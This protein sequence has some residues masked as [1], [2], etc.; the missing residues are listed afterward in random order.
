MLVDIESCL[1]NHFHFLLRKKQNL[2]VC[3]RKK[4]QIIT[5][6]TKVLVSTHEKCDYALTFIRQQ[7]ST[8]SHTHYFQSP[9][10]SQ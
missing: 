6:T 1:K 9:L 5:L 2:F 4:M 10:E 8:G 3:R 7:Q